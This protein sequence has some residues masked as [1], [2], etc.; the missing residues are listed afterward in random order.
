[1]RKTSAV[2]IAGTA[3]GLLVLALIFFRVVLPDGVTLFT[4][5]DAI[6]DLQLRKAS[7][8]LGFRAFWSDA[9]LA[10]IAGFLNLN[11]TNLLLWR[12]PLEF[13]T[14]WIHAVDLGLAAFFFYLFLRRRGF[15]PPAAALGALGA[16]WTGTNLFLC[17]AG[18]IGKYGLLLFAALYL[19]LADLAIDRRSGAWAA[20]AG[21]AAGG[22]FL[23]QPDVALFF[24]LFW[25]PYTLWSIH[26]R[27]LRSGENR[28]Y[29]RI[30]TPLVLTAALISFRPLWE[31]YRTALRGVSAVNRS[32]AEKWD[33]VTQWSWPPEESIDFVAPGFMGW[34]S[35]DPAGPYW[36]RM[37]RSAGWEQSHRGFMNFKLENQYLGFVFVLLALLGTFHAWQK[38]VGS[39]PRSPELR[40]WSVAAALSLLLSFGKYFPLY[41]ILFLVPVVSGI[42]NP[43]KFLHVFQISLAVLAAGGL[44]A[45]LKRDTDERAALWTRRLRTAAFAAAVAALVAALWILVTRGDISGTFSGMGWP[46]RLAE[47]ITGNMLRALLQAAVMAAATGLLLQL[48]PFGGSLLA[49]RL[50]WAFPLLLAVDMLTVSGHYLQPMNL[51]PVTEN[52]VGEYLRQH[53]RDGRVALLR[54][55]GPYGYLLTFVLPYHSV[56]AVNIVQMPRMPEDYRSLLQEAARDPFRLWELCGARFLI[57]PRELFARLASDQNFAQRLQMA[58]GF[59]VLPD[60]EGGMKFVPS[61]SEP[62][63]LIVRIRN[64]PGL[65]TAAATV[66]TASPGRIPAELFSGALRPGRDVV[67]DEAE[68]D[69]VPGSPSPAR[70]KLLEWRPGRITAEVESGGPALLRLAMRHDPDWRATIDGRPAPLL[71]C[72]HVFQ[73]LTVPAGTHRVSLRYEPASWPLWLQVAGMLAGAWG[74]M[75]GAT[76]RRVTR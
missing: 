31:G 74:L 27:L 40:F 61:R 14:D 34:R 5:D 22:M 13:F 76:R 20:G 56:P 33:F 16:F 21:M 42:R 2:E 64:A 75:W 39:S 73:A 51:S 47:A 68:A 59:D 17:Y 37:G 29:L 49:R 35:G 25:G 58:Y 44:Q 65:V 55:D 6:G 18:H 24:T 4:T 8:P 48:R 28:E 54:Q 12:L 38:T 50:P 45:W 66:R 57:G 69:S 43:N 53:C 1:M 52:C 63:H 26:R 15:S 11:W 67:V 10:G 32:Q 9:P 36:G 30:L 19:L 41:R 23:E 71:V 7:L 60:G 72:D 3:A 70:V 46:P 62:R